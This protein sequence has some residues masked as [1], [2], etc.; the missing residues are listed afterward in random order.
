MTRLSTRVVALALAGIAA[1]LVLVGL[2]TGVALWFQARDALDQALLAAAAAEAHPHAPERWRTEHLLTPV[3]VQPWAP[4]NPLA[5]DT[6]ARATL[7]DERPR[8]LDARGQRV[9]LVVAE[10]LDAP[11]GPDG[12]ETDH[13]HALLIASAPRPTLARAVGPFALYYT[14]I[15][16]LTA[17]LLGGL[18]A[19]G[20]RRALA[21]L[22]TAAAQLDDLGG[23]EVGARVAVDGPEE[24][25]R[26]LEATNGLLERLEAAASGQRRFV[27]D[28]AHELRTPVTRLLGELDLALR[29]D[30]DAQAYREA[31]RTAHD[32][33][34]RLRE[35][36]EALLTLA[37]LDAGQGRSARQ[38]TPERASAVV[39][40]A[41]SSERATLDAAGCTVSL[42]L[43]DDP[44]IVVDT[45]LCGIAIG[46]LLRNAAVHAPGAPVRIRVQR[47]DP[48]DT[49]FVSVEDGGPG[50]ADD[51]RE[52]VFERFHR[53]RADRPGLGLGLP[54]AREIARQ[55]GGDLVLSRSELGGLAAEIHI[56]RK[57]IQQVQAT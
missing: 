18:L 54:L 9:L 4:G 47:A 55:H 35:L 10:P 12:T 13:P 51:I 38:H 19:F 11:P 40:A 23:R 21:P 7:A 14:A 48:D 57:R 52:R 26:V 27:A 29:Q 39:L 42:E 5:D 44:E 50:L 2:G 25:R 6:L 33:A 49:V 30:R 53:G 56:S 46:N 43:L 31:L 8:W 45:A 34:A 17:T 24:V 3:Q 1:S 41:L 37:R 16:L 28:A 15:A 32:E 22:Q 36:V 20:L